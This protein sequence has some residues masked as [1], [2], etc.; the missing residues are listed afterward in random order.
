MN[1]LKWS[2]SEQQL[3]TNIANKKRD[4]NNNSYL[5]QKLLIYH[6]SKKIFHLISKKKY[7]NNFLSPTV[8]T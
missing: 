3:T 2:L 5:I 4:F 6:F 7:L 8:V 1:D